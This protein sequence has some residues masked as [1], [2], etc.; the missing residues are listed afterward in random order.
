M[1][2]GL[3][4]ATCAESELTELSVLKSNKHDRSIHWTHT[5][6]AGQAP[7]TDDKALIPISARKR[8][9]VLETRS[10]I[11]LHLHGRTPN[12]VSSVIDRPINIDCQPSTAFRTRTGTSSYFAIRRRLEVLLLYRKRTSTQS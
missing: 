4:I 1:L 7:H 10:D 3:G 5:H 6:R 9:F 11:N 2:S 8:E 12:N